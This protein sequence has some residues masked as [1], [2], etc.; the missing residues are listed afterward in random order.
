MSW[1]LPK[2]LR[3]QRHRRQQRAR[4]VAARVRQQRARKRV[5]IVLQSSGT[6]RHA[7][8][9]ELVDNAAEIDDPAFVTR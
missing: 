1:Y 3:Q 6:Y 4:V 7:T 9:R 2:Q 8:V 5:G